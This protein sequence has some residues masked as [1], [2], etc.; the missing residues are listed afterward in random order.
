MNKNYELVCEATTFADDNEWRKKR[1]M[2]AVAA[3]VGA[4]AG[5]MVSMMVAYRMFQHKGLSAATVIAAIGLVGIA[6]TYK[7][8]NKYITSSYMKHKWGKECNGN[9]TCMEIKRCMANI[10]YANYAIPT[11]SDKSKL[12]AKMKQQII[13]EHAK[14]QRLKKQLKDEKK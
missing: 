4:N 10:E 13:D 2:P 8:F 6:A 14:I 3:Q 5:I 1:A 7:A 12:K 9:K 11:M